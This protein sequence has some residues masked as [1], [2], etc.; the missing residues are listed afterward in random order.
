MSIFA[1][2]MQGF[3]AASS[4][5]LVACCYRLGCAGWDM[6]GGKARLRLP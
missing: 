1:A 2:Q 5:V 4:G 3:S 6:A